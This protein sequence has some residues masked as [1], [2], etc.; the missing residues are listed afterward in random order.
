[1]TRMTNPKTES[2]RIR[3]ARPDEPGAT[4]YNAYHY[5][6]QISAL[7]AQAG[8]YDQ[9]AEHRDLWFE[10]C[11]GTLK[12]LG[13]VFNVWDAMVKDVRIS[14]ATTDDGKLHAVIERACHRSALLL[15]RVNVWTPVERWVRL[16]GLCERR[17]QRV[18]ARLGQSNSVIKPK[19]ES[20]IK[21]SLDRHSRLKGIAE[22]LRVEA[23][24]IDSCFE[25]D[26]SGS[27]GF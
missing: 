21:G 2:P 4:F 7:Y 17:W 24:R 10:L 1:M 22:Q 5:L 26:T 11:D 6:T 23:G 19:L 13:D 18:L 9:K 3:L 15:D 12:D 27:V 8:Q 20:V 16:V 14:K 25:A